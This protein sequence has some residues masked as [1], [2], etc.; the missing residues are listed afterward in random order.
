VLKIETLEAVAKLPE[1]LVQAAG[2][3]RPR[4]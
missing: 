4:S 3:S 2:Q 1:F